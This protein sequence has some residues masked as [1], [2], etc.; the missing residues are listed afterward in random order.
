[1]TAPEESRAQEVAQPTPDSTRDEGARRDDPLTSLGAYRE[2]VLIDGERE[3]LSF[4]RRLDA[5]DAHPVAG[6]CPDCGG[7]VVAARTDPTL[8]DP[9]TEIYDQDGVAHRIRCKGSSE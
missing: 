6:L 3:L 8:G 1:M 9:V 7:A 4:W 2:L 5:D